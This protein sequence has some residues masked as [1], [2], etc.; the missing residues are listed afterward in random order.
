MALFNK[1]N[2]ET[3]SEEMSKIMNLYAIKDNLSGFASPIPFPNEATAIRWFEVQMKENP[4]MSYSP[5]DY[6]LFYLGKFNI[7]NGALYYNDAETRCVKKGAE[8]GKV[9]D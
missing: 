4:V 2:V 3:N 6:E 5:A 9:S 8:Y 1:E 7:G